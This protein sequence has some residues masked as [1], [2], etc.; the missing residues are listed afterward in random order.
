VVA[1]RDRAGARRPLLLALAA[2]VAAGLVGRVLAPAAAAGAPAPLAEPDRTAPAALPPGNQGSAVWSGDFP[3]PF[4]LAVGPL[5]YAYATEA[6]TTKVQTLV[7]PDLA[8]WSWVGDAL[9]SLPAWS[10]PGHVWAPSVL[11]TQSGYV[12]FYATRQR[13]TGQ[14]CISRAVSASPQGPFV[15]R[16]AAPF[17]CQTSRGGSIDPSPFTDAGGGLWL[18]WKSEGTLSGEPTRIWSERLTPAA[19]ALVGPASSLIS[20]TQPWEGPIVEGPSMVRQG[21]RYY[22][23]YSAN[24]W[25][26][27]SYAIGYAVCAGPAGPCAKPL[28]G[29]ILASHGDEAGPGSPSVFMAGGVLRVAFHAWTTPRVGYPAGARSLH[30]GTVAFSG[31]IPYIHG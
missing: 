24:R 21:G 18:A 13:S 1:S 19:D 15:D 30:I 8:H 11:P 14:Q 22:L 5:Y 28:S 3:D 20:T 9:A 12:M 26:T 2:V 10:Q 25:E 23:F 16:S 4:V 7:S 31:G 6:G 17:L 27:A 29:P